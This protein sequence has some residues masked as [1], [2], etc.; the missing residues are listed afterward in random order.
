MSL[1]GSFFNLRGKFGYD[2]VFSN[3][4]SSQ[5]VLE[6]SNILMGTVEFKNATE[7]EHLDGRVPPGFDNKH[8]M[9]LLYQSHGGQSHGRSFQN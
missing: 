4:Y 7:L 8:F 1:L 9:T 5:E 3:K 2:L 6:P